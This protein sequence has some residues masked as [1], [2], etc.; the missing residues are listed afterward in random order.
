VGYGVIHALKAARKYQSTF[1]RNIAYQSK[2]LYTA[3]LWKN[4]LPS[5]L[6]AIILKFN[7]QWCMFLGA[8]T[9]LILLSRPAPG[10]AS[11]I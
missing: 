9:I 2:I 3:N 11:L 10:K 4:V 6:D 8:K 1:N 5:I 7:P